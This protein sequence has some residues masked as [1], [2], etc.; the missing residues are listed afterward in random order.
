MVVYKRK[1]ATNKLKAVNLAHMCEYSSRSFKDNLELDKS[2]KI[3]K[4]IS[5]IYIY[6]FPPV[7]NWPDGVNVD[8]PVNFVIIMR[9]VLEHISLLA[10]NNIDELC[11]AFN[12]ECSSYGD[13]IIIIPIEYVLNAEIQSK[14]FDMFAHEAAHAL[15]HAVFKDKCVLNDF[16]KF[17]NSI[18]T[19]SLYNKRVFF[20]PDNSQEKLSHYQYEDYEEFFAELSS[21]ILIHYND[22]LKYITTLKNSSLNKSY[23]QAVNLLLNFINP[24]SKSEIQCLKRN[25]S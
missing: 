1:F 6:I 3:D 19:A 9:K 22:L 25:L 24:I 15:A 8:I 2:L 18:R 5:N 10:V 16:K 11:F 21:Q 23:L 13:K 7:L 4:L 12:S 20:E 17:H 14:F